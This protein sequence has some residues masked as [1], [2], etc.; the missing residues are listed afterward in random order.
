MLI[1]AGHFWLHSPH[2]FVAGAASQSSPLLYLHGSAVNGLGDSRYNNTVAFGK[3][4]ARPNGASN[5]TAWV[6]PRKAGGMASHK[7]AQ[8]TATATLTL[9]KGRNVAG[10]S[11]GSSTA[12]ATLQLVVSMVGTS[13]GSATVTGNIIAVL[14][15][16]GSTTGSG[17]ATGL[18]NALAW[19]YGTATGTST[20]TLTRYATGRLY[21]AITPYTELSPQSLA[22]A[23]LDAAN[24]APIAS[25]IKKVN[26]YSVVGDGDVTPWG[27]A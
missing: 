22:N 13:T 27:P 23:V 16:S 7:E 4:A 8:G 14:G 3:L 1:N 6:P 12:T 21:G 5:Q 24:T 19:A 9:T 15:M 18:I 2:R 20:A 10:T 26:D 11:T 25:N 17:T